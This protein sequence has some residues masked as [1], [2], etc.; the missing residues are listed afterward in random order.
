MHEKQK[1]NLKHETKNEKRTNEQ[2]G[3]TE[4]PTGGKSIWL[5]HS[6]ELKKL[7]VCC[8]I[9][10]EA[11]YA[12]PHWIHQT[13]SIQSDPQ[14]N[15]INS[16]LN[17]CRFSGRPNSITCNLFYFLKKTYVAHGIRCLTHYSYPFATTLNAKQFWFYR[18]FR[19]CFDHFP[20]CLYEFPT[21]FGWKS[22]FIDSIGKCRAIFDL[23]KHT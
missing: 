11:L 4:A 18:N 12:S 20:F 1:L 22:N 10:R 5:W 15:R 23:A 16:L 19:L 14:S 9:Q 7:P 17:R 3:M 8:W 13:Q 21:E 6:T 2:T